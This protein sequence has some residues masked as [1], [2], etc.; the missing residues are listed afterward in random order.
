MWGQFI[1]AFLDFITKKYLAL[2]QE[3]YQTCSR[4]QAS[5]SIVGNITLFYSEWKIQ[6]PKV[7]TI[8]LGSAPFEF[9]I[10]WNQNNQRNQEN[11]QT[12]DKCYFG[13]LA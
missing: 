13:G 10:I 3:R 2:Y 7:H 9:W 5:C 6:E 12:K 4:M 11:D 1:T 8:L